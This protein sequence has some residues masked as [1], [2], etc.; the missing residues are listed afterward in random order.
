LDASKTWRHS[1]QTQALRREEKVSN[2]HGEGIGRPNL[3]ITFDNEKGSEFRVQCEVPVNETHATVLLA[4][5]QANTL[6]SLTEAMG[7][8]HAAIDEYNKKAPGGGKVS[9]VSRKIIDKAFEATKDNLGPRGIGRPNLVIVFDNE[10]GS[11]FRVQC[12]VPLNETH[13]TVLLAQLQANNPKSLTEAMDTVHAAIEEYNKTAPSGG[14]VSP[15][16][17][18]II[19]NAFEATKDNLG[20]RSTGAASAATP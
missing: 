9:P 6:Q 8:V 1:F 14:Q 17:K 5:L 2:T 18:K 7:T 12:E 19:D 13:A 3:V 20:H 11:E 4:Q 10:K 15:V 16:S